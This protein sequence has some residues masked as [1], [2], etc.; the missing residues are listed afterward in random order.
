MRCK[1]FISI[2]EKVRATKGRRIHGYT[3]LLLNRIYKNVPSRIAWIENHIKI[4]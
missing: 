3:S 4:K 2:S 1:V